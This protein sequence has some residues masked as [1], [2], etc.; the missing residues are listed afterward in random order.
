MDDTANKDKMAPAIK[1]IKQMRIQPLNP[2]SKIDLDEILDKNSLREQL[3]RSMY[4]FFKLVAETSSKVQELKTYNK[5]IN[6]P[7]H[8]NR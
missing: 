4:K 1:K 7:I 6:D 3:V 8:Y 2:R 5:T